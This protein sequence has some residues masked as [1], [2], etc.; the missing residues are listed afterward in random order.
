MGQFHQHCTSKLLRM[1]IPKAQ[2]RQSTQAAF[3]A[4]GICKCLSFA[5]TLWWNW[6]QDAKHLHTIVTRSKAKTSMHNHLYITLVCFVRR[7][8]VEEKKKTWKYFALTQSLQTETSFEAYICVAN[9]S[10][11]L[12]RDNQPPFNFFAKHNKEVIL[13]Y[14]HRWKNLKL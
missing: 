5:S 10:V 4:F 2:K 1:Q 8:C 6:P 11:Q 3:F 12:R 13:Q 9:S 14:I 7:K